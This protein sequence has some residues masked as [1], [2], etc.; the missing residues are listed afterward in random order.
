MS[1]EQIKNKC[2]SHS[3]TNQD[4]FRYLQL[5]QYFTEEVWSSEPTAPGGEVLQVYPGL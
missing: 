4:F 2:Q 1:F 3:I 5:R